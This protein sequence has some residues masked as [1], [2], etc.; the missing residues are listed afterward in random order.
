M[1]I[2]R[3]FRRRQCA[4]PSAF[5]PGHIINRIADLVRGHCGSAQAVCER[6]GASKDYI[7]AARRG[8]KSPRLLSVEAVLNACGYELTI[9]KRKGS[10]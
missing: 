9:R 1:R 10:Q 2:E 8:D 3:S 4:T 6:A 7:T 5:P